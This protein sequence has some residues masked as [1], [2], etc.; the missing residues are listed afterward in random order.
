M[1]G[2]RVRSY[3]LA[4]CLV[5]ATAFT[6][7]ALWRWL[8]PTPSLLFLPAVMLSSLYGGLGPGLLATVGSVAAITFL[9]LPPN[10]SFSLASISEF[11]RLA[12]FTMATL[13]VTSL[14]AARRR[15]ENAYR[16]LWT[17]AEQRR[18]DVERLYQDLEASFDRESEA[19]ASRRNERLKAGLLDALTHNLRTPLTAMKA[20]ATALRDD[21]EMGYSAEAQRELLD[22]INEEIDRLDRF[23]GGLGDSDKETR[24]GRARAVAVHEITRSM[25]FKAEAISHGHRLVV[26]APPDVPMVEVNL[27]SITEALYMVLENA[28]KYSPAGTTI[29]VDV[30]VRDAQHLQI[31]VTD[32]GPGIPPR[33]R[34]RVFERFFRIDQTLGR[35]PGSGLGLSIARQLVESQGG[36]IWIEDPPSRRGARVTL[37]VPVLLGPGHPDPTGRP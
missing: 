15:T 34:E 25:L 21:G 1:I 7:S 8:A 32:E 36:Q 4:V 26:H 16:E 35:Q 13:L 14:T 23:V 12:I 6:T 2:A 33:L 30:A 18:L 11:V 9:F 37:S 29:S 17:L 10:F 24:S 5:A 31:A 3:G 19:E 20:A 22:V 27:A 28:A